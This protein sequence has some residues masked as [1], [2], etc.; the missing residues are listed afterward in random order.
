[1]ATEVQPLIGSGNQQH[2]Q[3]FVGNRHRPAMAVNVVNWEDAVAV[4][5]IRASGIS[6]LSNATRIPSGIQNLP[7]RRAIAIFNQGPSPIY[8]GQS[9]VT[10]AIGYPLPVGTEKAFTVAGNLDIWAIASGAQ[11][12]D[13]R[14]F[15]IA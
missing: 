2:R 5:A 8:I 13:V 12:V 11:P 7:Y 14:F 1:M 6:L 10:T 9:G 3:D 15:E 4:N